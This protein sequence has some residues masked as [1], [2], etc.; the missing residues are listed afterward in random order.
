MKENPETGE[1]GGHTNSSTREAEAG[2]FL[3]EW[4]GLYKQAQGSLDSIGSPV[5]KETKIPLNKIEI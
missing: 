1:C 4:S 5:S 3:E 2:E